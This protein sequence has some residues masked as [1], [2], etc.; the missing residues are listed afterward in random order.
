MSLNSRSAYIS[1]VCKLGM[2]FNILNPHSVHF[3]ERMVLVLSHQVAMN[4]IENNRY[5]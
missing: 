3:K 5:L 1:W 2:L 4:Q